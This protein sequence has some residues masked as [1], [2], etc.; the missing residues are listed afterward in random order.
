MK[1]KPRHK[2]KKPLLLLQN[3]M[4]NQFNE[5]TKEDLDLRFD[6]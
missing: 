4:Y 6:F 3:L 5:V 1:E 2:N